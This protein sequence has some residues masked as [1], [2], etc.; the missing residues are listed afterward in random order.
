MISPLIINHYA[1][2]AELQTVYDYEDVFLM[3][4][5]IR[6][7]SYNQWAIQ[8]AAEREAQHGSIC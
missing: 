6:V 8:K 5:C 7:D 1:T 4:E 3:L 2:L